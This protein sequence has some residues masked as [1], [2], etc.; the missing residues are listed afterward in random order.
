MVV[1]DRL[2][3]IFGRSVGLPLITAE[4]DGPIFEHPPPTQGLCFAQRWSCVEGVRAGGSNPAALND[5]TDRPS[6]AAA[7]ATKSALFLRC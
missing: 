7:F 6:A 4:T 5:M 2:R 1:V 3:H